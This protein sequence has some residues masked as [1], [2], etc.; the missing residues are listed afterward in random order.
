MDAFLR[1]E[2]HLRKTLEP[3]RF[4]AFV[5]MVEEAARR[6]AAFLRMRSTLKE[7]ARI[8][9]FLQHNNRPM[10]PVVNLTE[11]PADEIE[12]VVE[13]LLSPPRLLPTFGKKVETCNADDQLSLIVKRIAV[14]SVTKVPVYR[15]PKL[16]GLLVAKTVTR[17]LADCWPTT[18]QERSQVKVEDA[19]K[20][21]DGESLYKLMRADATSFDALAAFEDAAYHKGRHLDAILITANGTEEEPILGIV[22]VSQVPQLVQ[23]IKYTD[24]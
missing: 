16:A 13:I 20:Y 24:Y 19:L 14:A 23:S 18:P 9:N 17:W 2:E 6:D 1:I 11:R 21:Q 3:G 15:G 10:N 22:T 7:F 8:R 5:P 4:T 12:K